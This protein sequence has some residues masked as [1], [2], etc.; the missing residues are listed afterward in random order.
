MRVSVS[1]PRN[2]GYI[3]TCNTYRYAS[4]GVKRMHDGTIDARSYNVASGVVHLGGD[5][6]GTILSS[7]THTHT[8]AT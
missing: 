2:T 8:H 4:V 1:F 6:L 5:G 7:H 3:G